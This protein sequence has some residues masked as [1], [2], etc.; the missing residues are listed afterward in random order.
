ML[1][2][3]PSTLMTLIKLGSRIVRLATLGRTK[4]DK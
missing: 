3:P 1:T 2:V 4:G